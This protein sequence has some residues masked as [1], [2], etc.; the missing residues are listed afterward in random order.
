LLNFI[1]RLE[2]AFLPTSSLV[3]KNTSN[4][5]NKSV[6]HGCSF[7]ACSNGM[8]LLGNHHE[9]IYYLCNATSRTCISLPRLIVHANSK[10]AMDFILIMWLKSLCW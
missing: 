3:R 2:H 5:R 10:V 6:P 1:T 9:Q 7:T 8:W 4:H